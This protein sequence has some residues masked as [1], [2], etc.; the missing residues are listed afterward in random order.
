[1][2]KEEIYRG[3]VV[4]WQQPPLTG[5]GFQMNITSETPNLLTLLKPTDRI[6]P[7]IGCCLED[8]VKDAKIAIDSAIARGR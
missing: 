4:S 6:R 2:H 7:P 8:A 3:F 1:M 5:L